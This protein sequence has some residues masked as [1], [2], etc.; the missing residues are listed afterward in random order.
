MKGTEELTGYLTSLLS[1]YHFSVV[2]VHR[3]C[4]AKP[5]QTKAPMLHS[6]SARQAAIH[7]ACVSDLRLLLSCQRS[8]WGDEICFVFTGEW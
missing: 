3:H 6:T 1:S 8:V 5:I 7:Q 4:F 2:K